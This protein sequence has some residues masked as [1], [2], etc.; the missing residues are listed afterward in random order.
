MKARTDYIIAYGTENA[1]SPTKGWSEKLYRLSRVG[2]SFFSRSLLPVV[3]PLDGFDVD[4]N[5]DV[6]MQQ[7]SEWNVWTKRS[8]E[9]LENGYL[10][11]L[12]Q[13][14]KGESG[15]PR[16][17]PKEVEEKLREAY[18]A[19]EEGQ[20]SPKAEIKLVEA[21]LNARK[22]A[23]RSPLKHPYLPSVYYLVSEEVKR[24]K[25]L[26]KALQEVSS[27]YPETIRILAKEARKR[28][29][30]AL[31]QRLKEPP[32]IN[33]QIGPMFK[34]WYKEKLRG[35]IEKRLSP[36]KPEI[37]V[38]SPKRK[39]KKSGK[40]PKQASLIAKREADI[41]IYTGSDKALKELAKENLDLGEKEEL[42]TKGLDF[43]VVIRRSPEET[44][45]LTGEVKFQSDFGGNQDN[46][47]LVASGSIR[48]DLEKRHIGIVVVDG[49][50]VVSKFH[51]WA[52]LGKET[53]VTSVLLLPD[54]IA[55]LYQKGEEALGL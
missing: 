3:N 6:T 22:E 45:H 21:L 26:E 50:P 7:M 28:D 24:G 11:K 23:E 16:A 43:Y 49:M 2:H 37:E 36:T 12:L 30:E 8:V 19:Y 55:E 15:P 38:V 52:G 51:E 17:V 47:K 31:I 25:T 53:I 35:E 4:T 10:D 54:L 39:S 20:D 42:G 40:N 32:E 44:W 29:V 5:G 9:L 48:L 14:Y 33:Q 34:K 41:I 1:C 18:K 27:R 46:Q 13:V